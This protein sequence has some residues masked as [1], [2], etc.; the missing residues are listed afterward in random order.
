MRQSRCRESACPLCSALAT[1]SLECDGG[2]HYFVCA[3]CALIHLHP[4]QR[5]S[6]TA[7]RTRYELHE[8]DPGDREYVAFLKRLAEPVMERLRPG[9]R[10]L[11]FGCGPAPVLSEI[12]TAAGF[13]CAAY[14]P[15]FGPDE[16]LLD[17]QYDFV[18][19]SEVVE[20]AHDPARMFTT[21]QR[22]L[23]PGGILGVMTQFHPGEGDAFMDWWYHRDPTHVCFYNEATMRWIGER[24]SWQTEFPR[25]NVTIFT[26]P[27][28]PSTTAAP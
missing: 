25:P 24:Y 23:A 13:P 10:G 7:E 20:H 28:R 17:E 18:A 1:D 12:L 3:A 26:A 5:L 11:D 27:A 22:M 14:D 6:A 9:A 16:T 2:R 21:L 4:D 8:N 19:C 15:F